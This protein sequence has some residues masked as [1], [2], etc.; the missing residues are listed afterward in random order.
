MAVTIETVKTTALVVPTIAYVI[1]IFR[2]YE[3]IRTRNFGTDD[4]FALLS[5]LMM[6]VFVIGMFLHVDR[7]IPG[8]AANGLD[9]VLTEFF[10]GIVWTARLSILFSIVRIAT[11]RTLKRWLYGLAATFMLCWIVL[12]AQDFWNCEPQPGWKDSEEHQCVTGPNVALAQL[13]TD[14]Y[15]DTMLIAFPTKMLWNLK[16]SRSQRLRL[17]L[18]FSSSCI[19]TAVS[20][21]HAY[22]TMRV[23]GLKEI[24]VAIVEDAVSIM[25]CN[26]AVVVTSIMR[27]LRWGGEGEDSRGGTLNTTNNTFVIRRPTTFVAPVDT[28]EL[29]GRRDLPPTVDLKDSRDKDTASDT[30]EPSSQWDWPKH[31]GIHVQEEVETFTAV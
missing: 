21:V 24:T 3:R 15:A 4:A 26:T 5:T 13:I 17:F 1:T 30:H 11:S 22:Y 14:V 6:L 7:K 20:L 29:G 10:S 12:F 9:Y 25:V 28:I 18:V 16:V 23:G 2:L 31:G 27:Y 8:P 19:T